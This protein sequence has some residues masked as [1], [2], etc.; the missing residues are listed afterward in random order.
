MTI[1]DDLAAILD[2]GAATLTPDDVAT[3]E[4]AVR[5]LRKLE[6][7]KPYRVESRSREHPDRGPKVFEFKTQ[8]GA[9]GCAARWS[10]YNR[11]KAAPW[12]DVRAYRLDD[13]GTP[14]PALTVPPWRLVTFDPHSRS[15]TVSVHADEATTQ[16]AAVR[17]RGR[18]R[19]LVALYRIGDEQATE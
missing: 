16:A 7:V 8:A 1:A 12:F 3:V 18:G 11:G 15:R 2:S 19:Q 6:Q 14:G 9:Y 4:S 10:D 5:A 17:A 13:K